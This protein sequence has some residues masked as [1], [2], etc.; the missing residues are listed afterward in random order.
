MKD[1][2]NI[3][4]SVMGQD[5]VG[6]VAGIAK[7]LA[8]MNVSIVDI[9]Q[10]ITQGMFLMVLVGNIGEAHGNLAQIRERVQREAENLGVSAAVQHEKL[11]HAMH[12]I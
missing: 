10:K 4:I 3:V 5:R 6:I 1:S 7:A 11:F 8:E 12:R 9:N 2:A